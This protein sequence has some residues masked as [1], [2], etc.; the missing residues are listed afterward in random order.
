MKIAPVVARHVGEVVHGNWTDIYLDD[1]IA[2]VTYEEAMALPPGITN[3]IAMLVNHLGFYNGIV[4][5]RIDGKNPAVNDANGF[6][7]NINGDAE[8]QQLKLIVIKS[9]YT[10]ADKVKELPEEK[11]W[12]LTPGGNSSFYKTFQGISEHAHYHLGQIVLLKKIIRFAKS[13]EK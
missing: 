6:D 8:W 12:Q 7:V 4:S 13:N 5:A 2:D 10:L 1:T 9:F 11:L 3:S